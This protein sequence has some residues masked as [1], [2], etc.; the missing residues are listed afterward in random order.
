[1]PIKKT[2]LFIVLTTCLGEALCGQ[3]LPMSAIFAITPELETEVN[4]V[5]IGLAT[6]SF[7]YDDDSLTTRINGVNLELLGLGLFGPLVPSHPL[8]PDSIQA[9]QHVFPVLDTLI[10]AGKTLKPYKIN[11]LSISLGGL[12][13]HDIHMNGLTISGISSITSRVNGVSLAFMM[14]Y[15]VVVHGV[16]VGMVNESLEHKGLQIGLVNRSVR[17]R[18]FQIGLWNVNEKRALPFINWNF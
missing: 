9:M 14:N 3:V 5:A 17:T 12:A 8:L 16:S 6:Q 15:N 11:G 7:K 2:L 10:S 1:M 18:G 4:G 13:G